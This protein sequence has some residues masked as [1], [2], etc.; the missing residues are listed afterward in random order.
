MKAYPSGR[1]AGLDE[2]AEPSYSCRDGAGQRDESSA[3]AQGKMN[4][5]TTPALLDLT[6]R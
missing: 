6:R 4:C 3:R 5:S 1:M 2:M